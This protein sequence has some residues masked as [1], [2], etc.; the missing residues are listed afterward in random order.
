[1]TWRSQGFNNIGSRNWYE[2]KTMRQLWCFPMKPLLQYWGM[3]PALYHHLFPFNI[4]T[5][6][7]NP[8]FWSVHFLDEHSRRCRS[9][10]TKKKKGLKI[11]YGRRYGA[12]SLAG[13]QCSYKIQS[14]K[15]DLPTAWGPVVMI[16]GHYKVP[17]LLFLPKKASDLSVISN[18]MK[19]LLRQNLQCN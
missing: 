3:V 4:P 17:K 13:N 1:M 5:K 6:K 19:P 18:K 16:L 10:F 12:I 9:H 15:K 8:S 11:P 14:I 7:C 2:G